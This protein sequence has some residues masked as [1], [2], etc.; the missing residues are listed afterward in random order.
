MSRSQSRPRTTASCAS[1]FIGTN[2]NGS[3]GEGFRAPAFLRTVLQALGPAL[4]SLPRR[5]PWG[6]SGCFSSAT[7]G[8]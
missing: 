7:M 1:S 8:I 4:E 6:G 2:L 3:K 5:K